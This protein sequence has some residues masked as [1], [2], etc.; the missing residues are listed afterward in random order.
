MLIKWFL[1]THRF[2]WWHKLTLWDIDSWMTELDRMED[3]EI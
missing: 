2:V 1:T 3:Q